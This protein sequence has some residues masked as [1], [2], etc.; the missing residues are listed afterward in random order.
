MTASDPSDPSDLPRQP[1][2]VDKNIPRQPSHRVTANDTDTADSAPTISRRRR[3]PIIPRTAPRRRLRRRPQHRDLP[4]IRPA[5]T[6][7]RQ[8]HAHLQALMQRQGPVER[9]R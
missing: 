4:A 9:I 6:A 2:N 5:S 3:I 1:I 8:M 7:S